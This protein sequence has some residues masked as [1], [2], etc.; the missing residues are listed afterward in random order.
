MGEGKIFLGEEQ[1][2]RIFEQ[3]KTMFWK[4]KAQT[5]EKSREIAL[6]AMHTE[7]ERLTKIILGEV[8]RR[9]KE[10]LTTYTLFNIVAP[11]YTICNLL[12]LG[13]EVKIVNGSTKISWWYK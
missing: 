2:I 10:G 1:I 8:N 7:D 12:R 9:S 3:T 11:T 5:A 4:K 6:K 13:Y